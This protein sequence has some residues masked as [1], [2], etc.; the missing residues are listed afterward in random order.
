MEEELDIKSELEKLKSRDP[1]TR[2]T[3]VMTSGDRYEVTEPDTLVPG[4]NVL[5]HVPVRSGG[6]S[7]LRMNQISSID[8]AEPS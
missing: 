4:R 3:I 5:T 6:H 8:A 7:A 1:F 2:F